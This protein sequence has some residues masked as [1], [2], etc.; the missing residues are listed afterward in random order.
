MIKIGFKI[1]GQTIIT[2][3]CCQVPRADRQALPARYGSDG[4]V[5]IVEVC[6]D[7]FEGLKLDDPQHLANNQV[8]LSYYFPD[9]ESPDQLPPDRVIDLNRVKVFTI[10]PPR[11]RADEG[12]VYLCGGEYREDYSEELHFESGFSPPFRP[13][14]VGVYIF[15]LSDFGYEGCVLSRIMYQLKHADY[16][17]NDL[18]PGKRLPSVFLDD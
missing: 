2:W 7:T 8:R 17:E 16:S 12:Y 18:A 6:A 1:E 15:D 9:E 10:K 5:E 4:Q 11:H 14:E 3:Y 13:E